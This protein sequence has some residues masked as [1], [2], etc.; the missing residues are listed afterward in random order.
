MIARTAASPR[1]ERI[2]AARLE[3]RTMWMAVAISTPASAAS[4]ISETQRAA[5]S[6][7]SEQD[8]R[9]GQRR[10]PRGRPGAD[11]DRGSRDRAR[12]PGSRR[13]AG[14]P[15]WPAPGR[16]ARGRSRDAGPT[17]IPSAT[18]ADSRLSRAARAATATAGSSRASRSASGI[19]G[20][21]GAGSPVGIRP[22]VAAPSS[23][24]GVG[25]GG[26]DHRD[27]GDRQAGPDP[28][29]RPG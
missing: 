27:Q 2:S 7:T 26:C 24:R 4:G 11:V 25:Q 8:Q 23:E 5:T 28:C 14:S 6:T 29:P 9:M 15:G 13:T 21:C 16:R 12:S 18:V 10:Q 20:S 19:R 3:T 17:L 22:I 1:V